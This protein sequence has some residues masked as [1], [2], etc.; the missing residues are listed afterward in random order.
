MRIVVISDT[1]GNYV[2]LGTL[3]GDVLI[4]CGDMCNSFKRKSKGFADIDAWFR[5]QQFHLHFDGLTNESLKTSAFGAY[6]CS[7]ESDVDESISA[8]S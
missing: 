3:P 2:A 8:V 4:H 7:D 5:Q 6:C 1:H